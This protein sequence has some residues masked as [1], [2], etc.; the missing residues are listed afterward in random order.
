[1]R[2]FTFACDLI[3]S[4][5]FFKLIDCFYYRKMHILNIFTNQKIKILEMKKK[6][7]KSN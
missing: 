3:Y 1:M 2:L 4:F 6:I 5:Y 7:L